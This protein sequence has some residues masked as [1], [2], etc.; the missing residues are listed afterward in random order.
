MSPPGH[1]LELLST[2]KLSEDWTCFSKMWYAN[3]LR[4]YCMIHHC[5]PVCQW[6]EAPACAFILFVISQRL[7]VTTQGKHSF[8]HSLTYLLFLAKGLV[9]LPSLSFPDEI[10]NLSSRSWVFPRGLCRVPSRAGIFIKYPDLF[11][12]GFSRFRGTP[13]LPQVSPD[14]PSS[15][16]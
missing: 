12:R 7:H 9:S 14:L 6:N 13:H 5:S 16:P 8:I 15:S 11:R 1:L 4:M 10:Y 3:Y 2:P